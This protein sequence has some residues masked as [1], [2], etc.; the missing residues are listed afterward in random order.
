[1]SKFAV[2]VL[3]SALAFN[4]QAT[5]INFNNLAGTA[6]AGNNGI[7]SSTGYLLTQFTN[8]SAVVSGFSFAGN[9][10]YYGNRYEYLIQSGYGNNGKDNGTTAY[11][12]TDFLMGYGGITMSSQDSKPFSVSSIDLVGWENVLATA[13]FI[14]TR[15]DNT[16][17][18]Y[19]VNLDAAQNQNKQSG[20]DFVKYALNGFTGLTSLSITGYDANHSSNLYYLAADNINVNAVPEPGSLAILGLGLGALALTRRRKQS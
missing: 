20:N 13:T 16:T 6:V 10:V 15:A 9:G 11:N 3:F 8:T 18:S 12:G 2:A 19:T 14:G 1:M 7:S 5:V 17:I 4:A